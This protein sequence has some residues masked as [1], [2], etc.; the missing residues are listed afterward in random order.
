MFARLHVAVHEALPVDAAERHRALAS[1]LDDELEATAAGRRGST[2]ERCCLD[3]L[4]HDVGRLRVGDRVVDLDHVGVLRRPREPPRRREALVVAR[5]LASA[6]GRAD[7]AAR[8]RGGRGSRRGRGRPRSS[9]PPRVGRGRGTCRSGS[10]GRRD[11]GART[12]V[13]D[14]QVA[15]GQDDPRDDIPPGGVRCCAEQGRIP[16][17]PTWVS[18]GTGNRNRPMIAVKALLHDL[19]D[20]A[21]ACA[22]ATGHRG[23]PVAQSRRHGDLA[24]TAQCTARAAA[25]GNRRASSRRRWSGAQAP[26]R[27]CS[28]GSSR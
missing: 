9:R 26:A 25:P 4:H 11:Q 12:W 21:G 27:Q 20:A 24:C 7:P 10:T 14:M 17:S 15:Q 3:V 28:A 22:Q 5:V 18:Q 13:A 19:G 6:S 2:G 8:R 1:R 23:L 16:P